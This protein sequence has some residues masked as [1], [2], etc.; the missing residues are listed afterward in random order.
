M[1]LGISI[2]TVQGASAANRVE[3]AVENVFAAEKGF[4]NNDQVEAV[5]H[6]YQG[7][8][9]IPAAPTVNAR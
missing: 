1:V 2:G 4:D 6:V 5:E 8:H 3:V 9:R 7:L